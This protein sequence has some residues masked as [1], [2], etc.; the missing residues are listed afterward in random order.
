MRQD[1]EVQRI[2]ALVQ[3]K[4]PV[5]VYLRNGICLQGVIAEHDPRVIVVCKASKVDGVQQT[6]DEN[7]IYKDA[8]STIVV[9]ASKREQHATCQPQS[10]SA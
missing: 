8:I 6:G 7:I 9:P 4:T 1:S 5:R 3:N 10:V 2:D